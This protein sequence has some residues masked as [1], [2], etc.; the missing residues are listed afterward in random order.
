MV[1]VVLY[2]LYQFGMGCWVIVCYQ[3]VQVVIRLLVQFQIGQMGE[4]GLVYWDV[5]CDLG[6]VFVEVDLQDQCFGLVKCVFGGQMVGL[7]C[8]LVQ[9]FDI[10]CKL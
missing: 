9:C 3:V 4:F 8:K 2:Q 7:V 5:V 6:Q 10:G 1:V